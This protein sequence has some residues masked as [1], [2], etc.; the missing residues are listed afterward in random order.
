ME[1]PRRKVGTP[2]RILCVLL[3]PFLIYMAWRMHK[4]RKA[5]VLVAIDI[6]IGEITDYLLPWPYGMIVNLGITIP[7][8]IHYVNKWSREW[9]CRNRKN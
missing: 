4:V 3:S 6:A 1:K 9:E 2:L 5:L 7:L 8:F